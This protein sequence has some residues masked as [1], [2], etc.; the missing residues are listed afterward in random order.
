M[1][2]SFSGKDTRLINESETYKSGAER[3]SNFGSIPNT[4]T[5]RGDWLMG[6]RLTEAQKHCGFKSHSP[7]LKMDYKNYTKIK[8]RNEFFEGW[9][10]NK[11]DQL[12]DKLKD[13][14]YKQYVTKCKILNRD[15]YTCQNRDGED[16]KCTLCNNARF[17]KNLTIHHIKAKRNNGTDKERNRVTLCNLSHKRYEKGEG[18]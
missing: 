15:D 12:T 2:V 17:Y 14:V 1:Q 4:C 5:S 16:E 18:I 11:I 9:E 10:Q 13:G 8:S 7:H 3:M 6:N